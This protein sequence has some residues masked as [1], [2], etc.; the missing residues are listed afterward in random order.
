MNEPQQVG[1]DFPEMPWERWQKPGAEGRVK[2]TH[3]GE[4]RV[5]I[6]ELPAGFSEEEWCVRGHVGYVLKGQFTIEFQGH[7]VTCG[8]GMGFVIPDGDPHRSRGLPGDPTTVF[9]VDEVPAAV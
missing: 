1:I 6:L 9:V 7:E 3:I 5:R 2:M 4:K 8:P